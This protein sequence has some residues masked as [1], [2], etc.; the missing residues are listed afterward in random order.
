MKTTVPILGNLPLLGNLF[1][2]SQDE[3]DRE[4]VTILITARVV[5]P[6]ES[7]AEAQA[8]KQTIGERTP[9]VGVS[10]SSGTPPARPLEHGVPHP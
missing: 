6:E 7:C 10:T 8:L 5:E 4:K 2:T 9:D 3:V 1:R